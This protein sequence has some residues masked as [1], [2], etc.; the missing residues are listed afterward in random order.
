VQQAPGLTVSTCTRTPRSLDPTPQ[1]IV[2]LAVSF[3]ACA[4]S[5]W[6]SLDALSTDSFPQGVRATAF[7]V[8]SGSGRV[9]SLIAQFVNGALSEQPH[10]MLGVTG[11]C[12]LLGCLGGMCVRGTARS[13]AR[14]D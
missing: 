7:G 9:A 6:N 2:L 14:P 5:G 4:T 13:R 10:L 11:G 8:L 12:M 3:N 1:A